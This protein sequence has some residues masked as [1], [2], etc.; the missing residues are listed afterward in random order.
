MRNDL[1]RLLDILDAIDKIERRASGGKDLFLTDE[2]L[3]V[4]MI[5]HIQVIGEAASRL[6][7]SLR[8]G[9]PSIP[10]DDV[11]AMRNF[12]VHQYF[13]ID[14]EEIWDTV[15]TDVP[16]LKAE[17]EL[18]AKGLQETEPSD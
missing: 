3:Q 5:H 1:A 12:L 16:R 15:V 13:G 6:S 14:L 11:V 4:W 18:V 8:E 17:L 10:W 2:L 7:T 9:H